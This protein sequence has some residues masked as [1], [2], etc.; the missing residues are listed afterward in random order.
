MGYPHSSAIQGSRYAVRLSGGDK[1]GNEQFYAEMVP[2]AEP[3]WEEYLAEQ[4]AE[5]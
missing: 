3:M 4:R 2:K 5:E 1:T